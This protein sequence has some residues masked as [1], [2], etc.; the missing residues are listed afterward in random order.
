[1]Q[2]N[3]TSF[4]VF[5]IISTCCYY[6]AKQKQKP[7]VIVLA[8]LLFYSLLSLLNIVLILVVVAI[9]YAATNSVNSRQYGTWISVSILVILLLLGKF[10]PRVSEPI[11]YIKQEYVSTSSVFGLSF[12]GLQAIGYIIDVR[13][14]NI[15]AETSIVQVTTFLSF[16]PQALAGPISRANELM[17]QLRHLQSPK[18]IDI[19]A[20]LKTII[21]GY[22]CKLIIADKI[23]LVIDP[24]FDN[25]ANEGASALLLA[26]LMYSIQIYADFYAYTLIATGIA[27][28]FGISLNRNFNHPYS[29][30]SPGEFWNRWHISL[31]SWFRDYVYFSLGGR[32][33]NSYALFA[34]AVLT[35]FIA[36]AIWHGIAINFLVWGIL[37]SMIYL[38]EDIVKGTKAHR[39]VLGFASTR[40]LLHVLFFLALT[41]TWLVFRVSN[42]ADFQLIAKK[43]FTI[44]ALSIS[45]LSIVGTTM[46]LPFILCC[47]ILVTYRK[48]SILDFLLDTR[49]VSTQKKMLLEQFAI[50]VSL[51]VIVLF[52]G[53]GNREFL[54]FNF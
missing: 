10:L 6:A 16:F 9:T 35:T 33:Q 2:F 24:I 29:T 47:V 26:S 4:I 54:Y 28:L 32:R 13:R 17:P 37:H 14:K 30:S 8:S 23:G 51:L 20:A 44:R 1:M 21:F 46:Y 3:S 45:G 41:F 25:A 50:V 31:S 38:V 22:F 27:R 43:V 11:P 34:F 40:I 49:P 19:Y 48:R 18:A 5:L 7:L 12:Y 39:V 52:G 36:S 53:V 15:A 42:F